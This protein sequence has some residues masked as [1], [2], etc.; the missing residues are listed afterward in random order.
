MTFRVASWETFA[1]GAEAAEEIA[2]QLGVPLEKA[3]PRILSTP[4]YE[5]AVRTLLRQIGKAVRGPDREALGKAARKLD[6]DWS[7]LPEADRQKVIRS[8]AKE[9]LGVPEL[10]I[11]KVSKAILD[12]M[13]EVVAIAKRDTG[14][15]FRLH[16]R[17]T[18]TARDERIISYAAKSQ[19]N[20]ITDRYGNRATAFEAKVREIVSKGV[21]DGLGRKDIGALLRANV[22]GPELRTSEAY[23][24]TIASIHT[25][26]ARSWGQL[27]GFEEAEIDEYEWESVV[28]EATS[29]Q[30]R[31][32]H[33]KRFSVKKTVARFEEVEAAG[34]TK[35]IEDLQPWIRNGKTKDGAGVLFVE[36]GDRRKQIARVDEPGFGTKDKIGSYSGDVSAAVLQKL[37]VT[38]PPAHPRCRSTIVPA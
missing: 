32:L 11:G 4:G 37:G 12:Q 30:C 3:S 6:R 36:R 19:G 27:A 1:A 9:I 2:A 35:A 31:F 18:F 8:A 21:S 15:T 14:R 16:L 10:V 20:Y 34:E 7:K 17:P 25:S 13:A 23:W 26:R 38:A 33:G 28:D 22:I 29:E 24:E 5:Q